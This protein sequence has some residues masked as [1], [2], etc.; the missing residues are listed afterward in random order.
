[1]AKIANPTHERE[2]E[3]RALIIYM[4]TAIRQVDAS[5][6]GQ[7]CDR[8]LH[9]GQEMFERATEERD[10]HIIIAVERAFIQAELDRF[11][12]SPTMRTSLPSRHQEP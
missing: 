8:V 12:D 1:M 10:I 2:A 4:Q 3:A 11:G 9:L 6:Q 7:E 5:P